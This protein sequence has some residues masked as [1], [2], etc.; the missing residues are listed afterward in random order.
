MNLPVL[1]RRILLAGAAVS[2]A[3][4]VGPA[5]VGPAQAQSLP[6][7]V[8]D[9]NAGTVGIIAG[10]VD[11]TY[12]RIASDLSAV[13]DSGNQLRVLAMLGKGSLQNLQDIVLLRGVD[14]GIVQSDS[15]ASI[16]RQRLLGGAE[17]LIR[18]IAKLYDEEI[19]LLARPGIERLEDLAGQ[20][21]NVDVEGSGTAMTAALVFDAVGLRVRLAHDRQEVAMG[22]LQ[23]GEI[24]ALM[25][26]AGKPARLFSTLPAG[27]G[28]HFVPIRPTAALMETYLP[29]SLTAADYPTLIAGEEAVETIAVGAVMAVYAHAPGS[30]RYRKVAR[31][32]EALHARF[33]EF[34]RPPRHPKW[35]EVN[36]AAQLP[37]WTRFDHTVRVPPGR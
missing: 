20:V 13:L 27:T 23:R 19:H 4:A 36:L 35:R 21:V 16:R 11:G 9:A 1:S 10:G 37:G 22:R 29:G 34:L 12:I 17:G 31:F 6:Q 5:A 7:R 3:Q 25:F 33:D 32:V 14:L 30:D 28:L 18:Y 24:A 15:L 26:I 2:T 8:A